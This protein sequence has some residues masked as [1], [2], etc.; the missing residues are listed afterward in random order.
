ML[1]MPSL[2]ESRNCL[3]HLWTS[4]ERKW[5]Q[6][7]CSPMEIGRFLN[8]ELRYQEGTTSWC[9]AKLRHRKSISW[10]TML[11]GDVSKRNLKDFTIASNEFQH[12]VIR[13]SKIC[14]TEEKCIEMDK[15]AQENRSFCPSSEE[16]D[17]YRK[18]LYITLIKSGRNAPLK[19]RS[20]FREA[21]TDIHRLHRESGEERP[22][23]IPLY[24]Y[25]RWRS[26]SSSSTYFMVAV[27]WTLVELIN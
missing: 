6:Q 13:N 5:S 2:L 14:W 12:I 7:I 22:E 3:L 24:Q 25:Q 10:P 17:R 18:N 16:F 20:D 23:P 27:E 19:L 11:E 21:L 9:S 1:R 15:L 26:S 4:L 8:R